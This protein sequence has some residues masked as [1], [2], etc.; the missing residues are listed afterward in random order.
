MAPGASG[1][2]SAAKFAE[3]M[4]IFRLRTFCEAIMGSLRANFLILTCVGK[5]ILASV[6]S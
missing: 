1:Y 4:I 6:E 5:G 3:E 2:D